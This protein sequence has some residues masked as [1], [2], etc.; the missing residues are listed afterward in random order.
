MIGQFGVV[1]DKGMRKVKMN[2]R[3]P[4]NVLGLPALDSYVLCNA[5]TL[6]CGPPPAAPVL[7]GVNGPAVVVLLHCSD[8]DHTELPL[9]HGP[10]LITAAGGMT[11]DKVRFLKLTLLNV[12]RTFG[13]GA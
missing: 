12:D 8:L 5:M 9:V 4:E 3:T 10:A 2:G 1:I 7:N 11:A 13:I 6:H